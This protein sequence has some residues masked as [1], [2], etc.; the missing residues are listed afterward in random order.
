MHQIEMAYSLASL[1]S[2]FCVIFVWHHRFGVLL[3][4]AMQFLWIHYWLVT[5]QEGIIILDLGILVFCLVKYYKYCKQ[6]QAP[7]EC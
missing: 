5:G 6:P 7:V 3:G 2:A 4:F 1:L